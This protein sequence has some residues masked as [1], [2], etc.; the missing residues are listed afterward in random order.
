MENILWL[1]GGNASSFLFAKLKSQV[2]FIGRS[3]SSWNWLRRNLPKNLQPLY[4][5]WNSPVRRKEVPSFRGSDIVYHI[6]NVSILARLM[7]PLKVFM[8]I[9]F[10]KSF[11]DDYLQIWKH[12]RTGRVNPGG[13]LLIR[14]LSDKFIWAFWFRQLL[15]SK[16]SKMKP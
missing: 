14:S 5:R 3:I 16:N 6:K 8:L 1:S 15:M 9:P 12:D 13:F 10:Q 2:Q 7:E 11:E 4:S